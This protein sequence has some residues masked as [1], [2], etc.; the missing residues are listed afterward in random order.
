MNDIC[1]LIQ[2]DTFAER[3]PKALVMFVFEMLSEKYQR[4]SIIAEIWLNVLSYRTRTVKLCRID[5]Y[6]TNYR[7]KRIHNKLHKKVQ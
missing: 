2:L 4:F 6:R 1:R 7:K 5:F 3:F